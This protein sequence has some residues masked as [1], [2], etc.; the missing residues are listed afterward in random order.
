MRS[1]IHRF[2]ILFRHCTAGAVSVDMIVVI[3]AVLGIGVAVVAS[4]QTGTTTLNQKTIDYLDGIDVIIQPVENEEL[5]IEIEEPLPEQEWRG[6]CLWQ[7]DVMLA[8]A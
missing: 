5:F 8:C 7:G 1:P 6:D 2:L 4:V 3:A